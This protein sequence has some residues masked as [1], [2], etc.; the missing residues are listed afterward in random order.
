MKIIYT[1]VIKKCKEEIL[2]S[3]IRKGIS[4]G[5]KILLEYG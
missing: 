2:C 4:S 1:I 5:G 3:P